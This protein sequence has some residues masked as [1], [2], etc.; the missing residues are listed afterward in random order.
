MFILEVLV[1]GGNIF[2]NF[3]HIYI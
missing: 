3:T 2:F 1:W